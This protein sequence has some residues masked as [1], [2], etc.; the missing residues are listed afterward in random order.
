MT[1][2]FARRCDLLRMWREMFKGFEKE[3]EL[4]FFYFTLL[5]SSIF[6]FRVDVFF[7]LVINTVFGNLSAV[8]LFIKERPTFMSVVEY[9]SIFYYIISSIMRSF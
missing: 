3:A 6:T 5:F 8:E 7:F 4:M 2:Y 9:S 1:I